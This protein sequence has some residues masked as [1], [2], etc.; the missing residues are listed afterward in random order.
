M[1]EYAWP[2]GLTGPAV[3]AIQRSWPATVAALPVGARVGGEVIGRLPFG[4]FIRLDGFPDAV[5]LAEITAMPYGLELPAL[6]ARV[7]GQVF[8]H[9]DNHQ[10]RVRL[11]EWRT[12]GE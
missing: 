7:D 6:G 11:D 5:A 12:S 9:A 8:W 2:K 3:E 1:D 4:V 10:V